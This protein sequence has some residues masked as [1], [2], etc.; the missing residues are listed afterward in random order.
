MVEAREV[1]IMKK[2]ATNPNEKETVSGGRGTQKARLIGPDNPFD[3]KEV[4]SV[5]C[6]DYGLNLGRDGFSFHPYEQV[7]RGAPGFHFRERECIWMRAGIINF[8]VCDQDYDCYHCAFDRHMR[9]AMGKQDSPGIAEREERRVSHVAEHYHVATRPCIHYLSGRIASPNICTG[10]HE[11]HRC[12]VHQMLDTQEQARRVEHPKLIHTSGYRVAHGYYYH[13]GHAWVLLTQDGYA[14]IGI[15]DFASKVFG[16]AD[17]A[18]LPSVGSTLRQ[19]EVGWV[20]NRDHGG[21]AAMQSPL[22]GTVLAVNYR[23]EKNPEI[24]HSDPYGEGWLFLLDPSDLKLN[25]KSLY[26]GKETFR[27]LENENRNLLSL[28]GEEYERL[29]ATGGEPIDDIFGKFPEIGWNR[30][31]RSFL[32]TAINA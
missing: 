6:R 5:T 17:K 22:T 20:L 21:G 18:D 32:H 27:W 28:L 4:T 3:Y 12:P 25:L 11:C 15:D 24:M 1:R 10:E 2:T 30:L 9:Q 29:E 13:I 16:P 14:R 19:G 23:A 26:F 7:K 8:R 31:V